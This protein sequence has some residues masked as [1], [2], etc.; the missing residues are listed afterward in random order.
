RID[1]CS[2]VGIAGLQATTDADGAAAIDT[3]LVA[4]PVHAARPASAD[5]EPAESE[6]HCG[7]GTA[8]GFDV[9]LANGNQTGTVTGCVPIDPDG[10]VRVRTPD[11]PFATSG[12]PMHVTLVRAPAA[13]HLPIEIA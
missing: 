10:T 5:G 11:G 7:G 4:P 1:G 3:T 12:Q 9:A 13:M 6:D 8:T 2:A